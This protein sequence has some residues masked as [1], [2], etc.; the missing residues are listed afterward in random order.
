MVEIIA[1]PA[2]L[3]GIYALWVVGRSDLLRLIQGVRHVRGAVVRHDMNGDGFVPVYEFAH[4]TVM[5][6]VSGKTASAKPQ[7]PLGTSA[8]LSF[9]KRRPDLARVPNPFARSIMYAG[10]AAWLGFFSDLIFGWL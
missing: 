3:A 8:M 7:P 10:F 2:L 4:G 5:R 9:P 6:Q 1:V